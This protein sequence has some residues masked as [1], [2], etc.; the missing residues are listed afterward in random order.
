[1]LG[2]SS[3]VAAITLTFYIGAS[4]TVPSDFHAVQAA[5]GNDLTV[6]N[7]PWQDYPFRF[8]PYYGIRLTYIAPSKSRTELTLDY[9]HF[10]VYAPTSDTVRQTGVWHGNPVNETAPMD[11]RVQSFEITHGANM[12]AVNVIQRLSQS[13]NAFYIG[14]GPVVM[15][16]HSE[17]RIDGVPG[18]NILEYGGVGF[19]VLAG[20][21]Q[22]VGSKRVRAEL[23]YS[24]SLVTTTIADGVADMRLQT[25][26]ELV[27]FDLLGRCP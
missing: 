20:A 18:G 21:Q 17:S 24:N 13:E 2:A 27:G 16:P 25:F 19:Q 22:C 7:V 15:F 12:L 5:A 4:Q 8:S 1:M 3:I 26:H 6:R 9:T 11:A 10:K 14:G 23:K